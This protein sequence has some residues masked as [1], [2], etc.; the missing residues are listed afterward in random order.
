M[1]YV[2]TMRPVADAIFLF[3]ALITAGMSI[4]PDCAADFA[5]KAR[6]FRRTDDIPR[7]AVI[8]LI[9]DMVFFLIL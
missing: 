7:F 6:S 5:F 3:W 8:V 2:W 1:G 4:K 9:S